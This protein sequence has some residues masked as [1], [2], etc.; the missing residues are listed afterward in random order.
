MGRVQVWAGLSMS[1][2]YSL[3]SS[4]HQECKP[5]S[6]SEGMDS[7]GGEC[8]LASRQEFSLRLPGWSTDH[9]MPR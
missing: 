8:A 2:W 9:S 7:S 6:G 3:L 4:R 5:E 1:S